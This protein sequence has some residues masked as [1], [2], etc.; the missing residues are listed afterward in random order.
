MA[1]LPVVGDQPARITATDRFAAAAV[2]ATDVANAGSISGQ[3]MPSGLALQRA[4]I[5]SSQTVL[6]APKNGT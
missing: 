1:C 4:I 2:A 6:K 3:S 5:A